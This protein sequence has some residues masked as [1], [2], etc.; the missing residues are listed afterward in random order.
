VPQPLRY[1]VEDTAARHGAV[2]AGP[3]GSYLRSDDEAALDQLLADP[4]TAPLGLRRLAPTVLV[5]S[6][7]GRE[8]LQTLRGLG[9]SPAPDGH[10]G[11]DAGGAVFP[12][13]AL[14]GADAGRAGGSSAVRTGAVSFPVRTN[15]W[16]LTGED[17]DRQLARLRGSAA[18][19]TAADSGA[20]AGPLLGLETLRTAIRQKRPVRIGIVEPG[21]DEHR[22]VLLPLSVGG[23]RVR[24]YDPDRETERVV[25]IHRVMDIELADTEA[26]AGS[27]GTPTSKERA[28]DD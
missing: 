12:G 7:G 19:G 18:A 2:R 4:R 22:E 16:E 6:A 20:E 3:A 11:A 10:D 14:A 25:P 5:S 9:Y 1:L 17:L 24:V 28:A 26:P 21:G 15:P 8:L 27:A 23:G 13:A